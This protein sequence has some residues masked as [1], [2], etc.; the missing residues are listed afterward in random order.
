MRQS[1]AHFSISAPSFHGAPHEMAENEWF[2]GGMRVARCLDMENDMKVG[3]KV[4]IF[5]INHREYE[6]DAS[7]R[8]HGGPIY[9]KHFVETEIVG[10]TSRSW[11]VQRYSQK[12]KKK[13]EHFSEGVL[14]LGQVLDQVYLHEHSYRIAEQVRSIND[15]RVLREVANLIGYQERKP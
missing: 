11:I 10:E 3:D 13:P 9:L 14:T 7:G 1:G 15:V 8:S 5:D 12:K 2:G 4:F 6:M